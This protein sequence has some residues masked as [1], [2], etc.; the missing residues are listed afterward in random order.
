MLYIFILFRFFISTNTTDFVVFISESEVEEF[1]AFPYHPDHQKERCWAEREALSYVA[2]YIAYKVRDKDPTLGAYSK[3]V[4]SSNSDKWIKALSHGGLTVPSESWKKTVDE[5][6]I[7]FASLHGEND[8]YSVRRGV[9]KELRRRL[10]DKFPNVCP[11]A[12]IAY[13]RLRTFIR[14]RRFNENKSNYRSCMNKAK[15]WIRSKK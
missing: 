12:I 3:N 15:K 6:E 7:V 10:T 11:Q 13:A 9:I 14:I 1:C 2:G 8:M 4:P 5:F